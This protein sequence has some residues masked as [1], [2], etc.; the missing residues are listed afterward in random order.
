M[1]NRYLFRCVHWLIIIIILK[2]ILWA[3]LPSGLSKQIEYGADIALAVCSIVYFIRN[4]DILLKKYRI[5]AYLY[6]FLLIYVVAALIKIQF[7]QSGMFPFYIMRM[8]TNFCCFG[9]IFIFMNEKVVRKT[10]NLWWKY[11]P[12]LFIISFWKLAPSMYIGVLSFVLVFIIIINCLS[13]K[14]KVFTILAFIFIASKGIIQRIDYIIVLI[15]ILLFLMLH[16]K[17]FLRQRMA[18]LIFHC[19]MWIPL[20]FLVLGLSGTFNVLNFDSYV[21]SDYKSGIGERFNEDTR[22]F[23]YEEAIASAINNNYVIWGRTPGYGYD[24]FFEQY[25]LDLGEKTALDVKSQMAQR[26]SEV[27]VVNMFTWCG[28]LGLVFFFV[29]YYSIGLSI[30]RQTKNDYLRMFVLYI[31]FFWILCFISHQ[32]FVPSSDYIMLYI[33]IAICMNPKLQNVSNKTI[34]LKLRSLLN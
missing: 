22:T 2:N 16:Y 5:I 21:E 20:I 15:S 6:I 33:I 19:Q 14:Q 25:H 11:V 9:L 32:F 12:I 18:A 10:M 31:G 4:K 28:L 8:L 17:K 13:K 7:V 30:L 1:Q 27:F 3:W 26:A 24:S 23:L 34:K 29:F